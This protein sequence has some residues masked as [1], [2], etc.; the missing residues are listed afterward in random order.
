MAAPPTCTWAD[1]FRPRVL[2][3]RRALPL[4]AARTAQHGLR[5]HLARERRRAVEGRDYDRAKLTWLWDVTTIADKEIIERN[6]LGVDSRFY[7]PGPLSPMEDFTL[8]FPAVVRRDDARCEWQ[9]GQINRTASIGNCGRGARW[10]SRL[11]LGVS[12]E[13]V[14]T[15]NRHAGWDRRS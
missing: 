5:N 13:Q 3:S 12:H 10:Y 14:Q 6:Q 8:Q 7:E 2:R 15:R 11:T 1:D 4:H 9:G